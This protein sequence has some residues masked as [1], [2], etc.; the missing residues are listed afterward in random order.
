[1]IALVLLFFTGL[2]RNL[3]D[4]ILAAIVL[5]AVKGLI[6]IPELKHLQKV[7]RLEFQIALLALVGVLLFV[8]V[9][10][11]IKKM[12]YMELDGITM[13]KQL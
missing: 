3:P 9:Q 2:F 8:T 7:S 13:N 10:G 5:V 4:A 11:V 6:N 1:M 12:S